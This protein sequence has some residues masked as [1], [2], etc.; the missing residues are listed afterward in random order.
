MDLP[1]RRL[2]LTASLSRGIVNTF[3]VYQTYYQ[4]SLLADHTASE[5]S[6]IGTFQAFLLV[7]LSLVAG[8]IFDRGHFRILLIVGTFLTVFGIMASLSFHNMFQTN[9]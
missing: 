9:L 3:G 7:S 1:L 5:I 8:P 2:Y 4:S 6:W